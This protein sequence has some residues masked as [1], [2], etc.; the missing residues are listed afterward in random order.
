MCVSF[1]N[2]VKRTMDN[3][4]QFKTARKCSTPGITMTH[5]K[6]LSKYRLSISIKLASRCSSQSLITAMVCKF[7]TKM[8]YKGNV[9]HHR[10][11]FMCRPALGIDCTRQLGTLKK[12]FP[13]K[14]RPFIIYTHSLRFFG[15]GERC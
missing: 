1:R 13:K 14:R 7:I 10:V 2:G 8:T 11:E 15:S 6:C 4:C 3:E 12:L 5:G 9:P